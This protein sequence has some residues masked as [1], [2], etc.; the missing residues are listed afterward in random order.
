ML[1]YM[2]NRLANRPHRPR[3]PLVRSLMAEVGITWPEPSNERGGDGGGSDDD[4]GGSSTSGSGSSDG[5]DEEMPPVASEVKEPPPKIEEPR[6]TRIHGFMQVKI[7]ILKSKSKSALWISVACSFQLHCSGLFPGGLAVA[8][9]RDG[10]PDSSVVATPPPKVPVV[11][12]VSPTP[13]SNPVSW[14]FGCLSLPYTFSKSAL[15]FLAIASMISMVQLNYQSISIRMNRFLPHDHVFW[16]Q[17]DLVR[18]QRQLAMLL[19]LEK[20]LQ[21]LAHLEE[22]NKAVNPQNESTGGPTQ[23]TINRYT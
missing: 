21:T 13:I 9:Y 8:E 19:E 12:V 14:L 18:K 11:P 1:S 7:R 10:T 4:D 22:L 15:Q 23:T 6:G 17:A 2:R 5:E 16:L 20:Q 3:D